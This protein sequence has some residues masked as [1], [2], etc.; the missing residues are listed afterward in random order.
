M[1]IDCLAEWGQSHRGDLEIA[2]TQAAVAKEVGC[3]FSKWQIFQTDRLVSASAGRYWDRHLGGYESQRDTFNANGMLTNDE[4]RELA[5]FCGGLGVTFLATPFDLEA[6][7]LLEDIGVA[8][9]KLASGDITYRH[10]IQKV[11][12]TGKPVF[13][14]TG[15]ADG[16]EVERAV[17]WLDGSDVTLLACTL[18]YPTADEDANLGRIEALR[19]DFPGH[20][21]GLSDHTLRT[22]TALAAVVAGAVMLEKHA[23][24]DEDGNV[25]DDKMALNPSRLR[26]YVAY[27][28]L[29]A[30]MRGTGELVATEAEMAARHGARRSLHAAMDIEAGDR[31]QAGDFICLRPAGPFEPAD[32]DVLVGKTAAKDI[33]V[34]KQIE[35]YDIRF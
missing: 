6:V 2:K 1:P 8:A 27:A 12:A 16:H 17:D 24:L 30:R 33:P 32:V 13:L 15:A 22:D 23:T 29:G 35:S 5:A 7:D 10:L 9:Y 20:R 18:A 11:A 14:S 3:S 26:Q 31:F 21:V 34:G 19:R 28:Q 4:W 25:P